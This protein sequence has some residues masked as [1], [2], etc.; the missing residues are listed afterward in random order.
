M[1]DKGTLI[2]E[3][4]KKGATTLRPVDG[5]PFLVLNGVY[6][7]YSETRARI[8]AG[9]DQVEV[10]ER[11]MTKYA[12]H[13]LMHQQW[14]LHK[15][16]IAAKGSKLREKEVAMDDIVGPVM[17]LWE[18]AQQKAMARNE[19]GDGS[20]ILWS[21]GALMEEPKGEWFAGKGL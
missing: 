21:T 16:N 8:T 19:G 10:E 12:A 4:E 17:Q 11:R 15:K 5:E 2:C 6:R 1:D 20:T 14:S 18:V 13:A 7:L 3:A 9:K